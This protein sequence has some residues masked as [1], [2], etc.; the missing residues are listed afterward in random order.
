MVHHQWQHVSQLNDAFATAEPKNK[1]QQQPKLIHGFY[2]FAEV[3]TQM[4]KQQGKTQGKICEEQIENEFQVFLRHT[5]I[6]ETLFS[7]QT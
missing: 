4:T 1:Q 7:L 6:R 5:N 3:P 2:L